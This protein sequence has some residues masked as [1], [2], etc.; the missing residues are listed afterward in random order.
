MFQIVH[1]VT[2]ENNELTSSL[3]N[4]PPPKFITERDC[5]YSAVD[6]YHGNCF[7]LGVNDYAMSKLYALANL[8]ESKFDQQDI[9]LAVEKEC[10]SLQPQVKIVVV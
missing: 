3:I 6:T 9:V 1:T 5:Y 4:A 10:E 2:E 8:C 7:N